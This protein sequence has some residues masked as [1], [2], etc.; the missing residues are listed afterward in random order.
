MKKF[1]SMLLV[2]MLCLVSMT[3]AL[4]EGVPAS[5]IKVGFIFVGDENE[6]YTAAHYEGAKQMA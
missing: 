1:V 5:E 3:A 6:G 2:L 4:A